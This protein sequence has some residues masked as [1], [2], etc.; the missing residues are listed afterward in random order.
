MSA[1]PAHASAH[2]STPTRPHAFAHG[3]RRAL[4]PRSRL[5]AGWLLLCV[6]IILLDAAPTRATNTT[7]AAHGEPP[8]QTPQTTSTPTPTPARNEPRAPGSSGSSPSVESRGAEQKGLGRRETRRETRAPGSIMGRVVTDDGHPVANAAVV[9]TT[10]SGSLR[11]YSSTSTDEDGKFRVDNLEPAAYNVRAAFDGYV[12]LPDPLREGGTQG[13]NH[14]GDFVSI[15]L[16]KGGVITG[17]VTNADGEPLVAV[18]VRAVFVRDPENRFNGA[19]YFGFSPE[20][21]TDDRGIYRIFGL[22]PGVY[23]VAV[24]GGTPRINFLAFAADVESPTYFPSHNRDGATEITVRAGQ[25]TSGIDIRYRGEQGHA[26]GG[27]VEG[28]SDA[29]DAPSGIN[30]TL[31]HEATGTGEFAIFI[32][33]GRGDERT[34]SFTG[35]ADG[36]YLISANRTSRDGIVQASTP[37]RVSV[38]GAD[39][40]GLSLALTPLAAVAGRVH[41]EAAV[42]DERTKNGCDAGGVGATPQETVV[43]LRRDEKEASKDVARASRWSVRRESST[44]AQGE[45]EFR[46]LEAGRYRLEAVPP[47][48]DWYVRSVSLP[49]A[50]V[51]SPV[52][53]RRAGTEGARNGAAATTAATDKAPRVDAGRTTDAAPRAS[54]TPPPAADTHPASATVAAARDSFVLKPNDRLSN[55]NVQIAHGAAALRGQ[56]LPAGEG[57]ASIPF[58]QMRVHLVPVAREQADDPLR[59]AESPVN[60]DGAFAFSNLAPGRYRL[61]TRLSTP[62]ALQQQQLQQQQQPTRRP[63]AWDADERAR[64]RLEAEAANINVEL[65]PCQRL[66]GFSLKSSK[67]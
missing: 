66:D 52:T 45:F 53:T 51:V 67:Q 2:G 55:L 14:V 31:T 28:A 5:F 41:I 17:R 25:E 33:P 47:N 24:G 13:Y 43:V 16:I 65:Q 12:M 19:S 39:V 18:R 40:T 63:A 60:A 8:S 7:D 48:A 46:G 49:T 11:S 27:I 42:N 15:T 61:L 58:A 59:F 32:P 64:L 36:D 34:F 4:R 56:I 20:Q 50:N 57:A 30:I 21:Q 54:A 35:V 26:V 37:R 10:P 29:D 62:D 44:G 23:V 22:S 6:V 3:A 9:V 38:R 1:R